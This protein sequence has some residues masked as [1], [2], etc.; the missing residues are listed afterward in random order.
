MCDALWSYIKLNDI[1]LY[2]VNWIKFLIM[3][4][5]SRHKWSNAPSVRS[6][7]V[8]DKRMMRPN[9]W[10]VIVLCVPFIAKHRYTNPQEFFSRTV[11][12]G[13]PKRKP[14]DPGLS[15]K[16]TVDLG[17]CRCVCVW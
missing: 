10:L 14:A 6:A 9:H 13:G 11:I 7:V 12:G 5:K 8:D 4:L 1:N 15:G 17:V 2:S 3:A 16:T